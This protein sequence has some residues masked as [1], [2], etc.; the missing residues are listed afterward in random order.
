VKSY[1]LEI[2]IYCNHVRVDNTK[3]NNLLEGDHDDVDDG[4]VVNR[5]ADQLGLVELRPG[6]PD[7]V[8]DPNAPK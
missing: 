7:V 1:C 6:F 4:D 8:A 3:E 2:R 5:P